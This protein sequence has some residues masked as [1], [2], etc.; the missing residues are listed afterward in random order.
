MATRKQKSAKSIGDFSPVFAEVARQLRDLPWFAEGWSA[1]VG[2]NEQVTWLG[3]NKSSWQTSGLEVHFESWIKKE[4]IAKR[5]VPVAMHVEGGHYTRRYAFNTLFH[6]DVAHLAQAWDGYVINE[7]GMT[8][9][10]ISVPMES[11]TLV[12]ALVAEFARLA[13]LG[14]FVDRTVDKMRYQR[15]ASTNS[16]RG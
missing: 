9:L 11:D 8:R 1:V 3:L 12:S 14:P 5:R 15:G 7:S 4:Q 10:A 2:E 6:A 16:D 13:Q